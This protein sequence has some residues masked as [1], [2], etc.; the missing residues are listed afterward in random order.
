M[1]SVP[2]S[3][4][5]ACVGLLFLVGMPTA[6][7]AFEF[8]GLQAKLGYPFLMGAQYAQSLNPIIG[9]RLEGWFDPGLPALKNAKV[10]LLPIGLGYD[11]YVVPDMQ[12]LSAFCQG[13]GVHVFSL[14]SG[15]LVHAPTLFE[16]IS[17]YGG[18]QVG[19]AID[20]LVMSQTAGGFGMPN[21]GG[22]ALLELKWG[23]D[24][25]IHPKFGV[26][27][28]NT[29]RILSFGGAVLNAFVMLGVR[30]RP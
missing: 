6:A 21:V 24:F 27:L 10:L 2:I 13:I 16:N 29:T 26:Q 19:I 23:L 28:E 15:I 18:A 12:N 25:P 1:K 3:V 9:A 14:Y 11:T 22:G 20:A 8:H 30:Y 5:S 17:V 7:K 4:V